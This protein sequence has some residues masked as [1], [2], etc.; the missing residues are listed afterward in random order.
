MI[1]VDP[2]KSTNHLQRFFFLL[3]YFNSLYDF[4][5]VQICAF[6]QEEQRVTLIDDEDA[7]GNEVDDDFR[8]GMFFFFVG[9]AG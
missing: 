9:L 2:V 5:I 3:I 6:L 8:D 7:Y 4:C 1:K